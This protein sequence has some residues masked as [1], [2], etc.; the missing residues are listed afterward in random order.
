MSVTVVYRSA[1]DMN[2]AEYWYEEGPKM[3]ER[4]IKAEAEVERL[5]LMVKFIMGGLDECMETVHFLDAENAKL[6]AVVEAARETYLLCVNV[7]DFSNGVSCCGIDE[8]EEMARKVFNKLSQALA[9]LDK[10]DTIE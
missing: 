7:G 2:R 1:A 3:Q 10:G 4:V 9:E 5:R 6:R 8:G